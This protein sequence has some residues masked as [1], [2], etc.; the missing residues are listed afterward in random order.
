MTRLAAAAVLA[1]FVRYATCGALSALVHVAVLVMLVEFLQMP[2]TMAS[3][4]GFACAIP[5]NYLLQHRFVFGSGGGH[6]SFFPR[7]LAVTLLSMGLNVAL[8]WL[9]TFWV[10]LHYVLAQILALGVVVLVNFAVNRYFTFE[11][12]TGAGQARV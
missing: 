4:L 12:V 10:G 9:L 7:Y 5:V 11:P 2:S 1:Q 6:Q 8:H 3:A